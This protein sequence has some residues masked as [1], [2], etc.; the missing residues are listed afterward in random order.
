MRHGG[1]DVPP[2]RGGPT[3]PLSAALLHAYELSDFRSYDELGVATGM[4]G[5]N[6]WA[7]CHGTRGGRGKESAERIRA[8]AVALG[9]DPDQM[10]E[11]ADARVHSDVQDAE[12]VIRNLN[13]PRESQD[14]LI[15]IL[16][17]MDRTRRRR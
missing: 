10:I 5:K 6:A 15:A 7:Y 16:R 14:E 1:Q 11:L 9:L 8:L 4:S 2:K 3:T 13:W 17:D 12:N